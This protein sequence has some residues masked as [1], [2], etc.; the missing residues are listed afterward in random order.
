M[1]HLLV[2]IGMFLVIVAYNAV[3]NDSLLW[4]CGL[5]LLAA[6]LFVIT[7]IDFIRNMENPVWGILQF[8]AAAGALFGAVWGVMDDD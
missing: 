8:V 5:Y 6:T 2:I 4:G 7:G 3:A 1:M